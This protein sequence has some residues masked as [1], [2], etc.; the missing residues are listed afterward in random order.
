MLAAE[1][2]VK[3]TK[4]L[5]AARVVAVRVAQTL[6]KFFLPLELQTQVVGVV[7]VA[8]QRATLVTLAQMAA[9]VS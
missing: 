7:V 2:A 4:Y 6:E 8:V 1:A 5:L 9:Q 3:T